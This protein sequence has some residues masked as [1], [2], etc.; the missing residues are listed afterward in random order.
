MEKFVV[1]AVLQA[2]GKLLEKCVGW[3]VR[4]ND[5]FA[6][7]NGFRGDSAENFGNTG[8]HKN[9]V[10]AVSVLESL[11]VDLG[12]I[13]TSQKID[14]QRI[15]DGCVQLLIMK[16]FFALAAQ[17]RHCPFGIRPGGVAF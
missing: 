8:V 7:G 14:W 17:V 2:V 6:H 15:L 3:V 4:D 11:P 1:R 12:V 16:L 10:A 5:K 13:G 9:L